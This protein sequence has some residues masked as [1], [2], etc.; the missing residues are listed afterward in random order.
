[1][2]YI[3]KSVC[4]SPEESVQC[5]EGLD[6]SYTRRFDVVLDVGGNSEV[7]ISCLQVYENI[8][9]L[10]QYG[11][12]WI[13]RDGLKYD[14]LA[15]MRSFTGRRD[16]NDKAKFSFT[17][18]Y[19]TKGNQQTPTQPTQRTHGG[20]TDDPMNLF[21]VWSLSSEDRMVPLEADLDG[22]RV[23]NSAG[24][25]YDPLPEFNDKIIVL[26]YSRYEISYDG[27][28]E[29]DLF[30]DLVLYKY[31]TNSDVFLQIGDENKWLI[32]DYKLTPE[33]LGNRRIIKRDIVFKYSTRGW[34]D[35]ILD[36]GLYEVIDDALTRYDPAE[37]TGWTPGWAVT[38]KKP[39]LHPITQQPVTKPWPLD[40]QGRALTDLG[41]DNLVYREYR[42][43]TTT[44]FAPLDIQ[45]I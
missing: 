12:P 6:R 36:A 27:L 31:A 21:P 35:R 20:G 19:S 15:V 33:L 1:M 30:N 34:K 32:A 29:E 42:N 41:T 13:S 11:D 2:A 22:R 24:D 26:N 16:H 40:G 14:A 7:A 23:V 17:F 44:P 10:P 9:G 28:T 39:I 18:T 4:E 3:A 38:N 43:K 8:A 5:G 25:P 45:L 37:P